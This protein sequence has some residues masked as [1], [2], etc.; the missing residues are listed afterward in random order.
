VTS[1]F[2]PTLALSTLA[3]VLL[4]WAGVLA[5]LVV[6]LALATRHRRSAR[7][8][9]GHGR[10]PDRRAGARDRRRGD[11]D[12]RVGLPDLRA[13]PVER[14]KVADRRHGMPDRRRS[15]GAA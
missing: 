11:A 4:A 9:S 15:L 12:R 5:L 8:G 7:P 3:A 10:D 13:Q 1:A 6:G 14:R 2:A